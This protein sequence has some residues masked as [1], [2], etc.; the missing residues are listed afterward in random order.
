MELKTQGGE[1]VERLYGKYT[2]AS[3][4][5]YRCILKEG[6]QVTIYSKRLRGGRKGCLV[7]EAKPI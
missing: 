4:E 1:I 3:H 2:S 7:H 6:H 5:S